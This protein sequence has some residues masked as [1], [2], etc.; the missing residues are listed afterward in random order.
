MKFKH[1]LVLTGILLLLTGPAAANDLK[2]E[3][4]QARAATAK[5]HDV[6]RAEADGYVADACHV[7]G[8]HWFNWDLYDQTFDIERPE[9]LNYV[10]TPNGGWRLVAV[11]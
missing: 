8:C 3:L 11:E 2:T 7:D 9:A 10:P 6:S 1:M 5:Y 4:A